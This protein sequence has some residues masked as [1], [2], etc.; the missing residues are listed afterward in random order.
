M[1]TEA[2]LRNNLSSATDGHGGAGTHGSRCWGRSRENTQRSE[3]DL[4]HSYRR[5]SGT[6]KTYHLDLK[7]FDQLVEKGS[8]W[9]T[10]VR[11]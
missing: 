8:V 4:I 5:H 3:R 11:L 9:S 2:R 7:T 1:N 10:A 6:V